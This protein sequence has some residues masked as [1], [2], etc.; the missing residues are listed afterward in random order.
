MINLEQYD[1]HQQTEQGIGL[2]EFEKYELLT[3]FTNFNYNQN[4]LKDQYYND[5]PHF[6]SQNKHEEDDN[7]LYV[8]SK[9]SLLNVLSHLLTLETINDWQIISFHYRNKY[10]LL[11]YK[12]HQIIMMSMSTRLI[13]EISKQYNY[14]LLKQIDTFIIYTL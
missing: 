10:H 14:V 11:I 4:I 5:L 12:I 7:T 1:H 2:D 8:C 6:N 3:L 9:H 13:E